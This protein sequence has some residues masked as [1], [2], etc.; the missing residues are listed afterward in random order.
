VTVTVTGVF[1]DGE[2]VRDAY[3]GMIVKVVGD[4]V[5]LIAQGT[6]LLERMN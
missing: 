6:V 4:S 5:S 3:S 1:K 2:M